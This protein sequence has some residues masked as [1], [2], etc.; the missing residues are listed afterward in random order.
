MSAAPG[1]DVAT[2]ARIF[3]VNISSVH[4]LAKEPGFPTKLGPGVFDLQKATIWYIRYLQSV[5]RRRGPS[6]G[7]ETA[8]VATERLRVLKGQAVKIELGN[9][10]EQGEYLEADAVMARWRRSLTIIRAR[11][12]AMPQKLAPLLADKTPGYVAEEIR[13]EV[14][15]ALTEL[16]SGSGGDAE[17]GKGGDDVVEEI[18][19]E[20]TDAP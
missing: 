6:G 12:L 2:V 1:V 7:P 20:Q 10:V 19:N 15:A 3:G 9:A 16:A 5:V 8:A 18:V 11:L 14:F 17:T 13:R 4:R